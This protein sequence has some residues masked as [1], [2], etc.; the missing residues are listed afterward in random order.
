MP[1][2]LRHGAVSNVPQMQSAGQGFLITGGAEGI[3]PSG[4]RQSSLF[5]LQGSRVESC[6]SNVADQ[7]AAELLNKIHV[8]STA[9]VATGGSACFA[10]F[11]MHCDVTDLDTSSRDGAAK[12]LSALAIRPSGRGRGRADQQMLVQQGR[13]GFARAKRRGEPR[14]VGSERQRQPAS[15]NSF[16]MQ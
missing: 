11:F 2:Y 12:V 13:A 7:S 14:F 10:D 8:S 3:G 15:P 6:W 1:S 4:Q 16:L 9:V 5:W